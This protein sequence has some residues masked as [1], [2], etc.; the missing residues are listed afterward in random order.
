MIKFTILYRK[1]EDLSAFEQF[2]IT[3]L[4]LMER[5]PGVLRREV[6]IVYGAPG[7]ESTYH[8][9]LELYFE[10]KEALTAGLTSEAGQAAGH[11]LMQ[12][13]AQL[14]DLFFSEVF[15]EAG[16]FT[17]DALPVDTAGDESDSSAEADEAS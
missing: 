5:I 14:A 12:H 9:A 13:A 17:P 2:Y 6:S 16:G 8:R 3:N 1:P 11:H 7:G 4:A 15:E 10:D